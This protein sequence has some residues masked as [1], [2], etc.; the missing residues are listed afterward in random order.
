MN[1]NKIKA[2]LWA[3][4]GLAPLLGLAYWVFGI[5]AFVIVS[6]FLIVFFGFLAIVY[7]FMKAEEAWKRG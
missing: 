3:L 2:L 6:A 4:L 7:C 1:K 5:V